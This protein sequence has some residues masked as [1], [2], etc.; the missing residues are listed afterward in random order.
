[1]LSDA[2]KG[3]RVCNHWMGNPSTRVAPRVSDT[4][5]LQGCWS[6][7][8]GLSRFWHELASGHGD[9]DADGLCD[10][11]DETMLYWQP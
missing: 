6:G 4:G 8:A 2:E 3:Q 10:G 7:D 1:V 11:C 9:A 5:V